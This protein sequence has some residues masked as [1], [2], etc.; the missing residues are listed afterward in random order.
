M[1][2]R[3]VAGVKQSPVLSIWSLEH[4]PLPTK[5]LDSFVGIQL[6]GTPLE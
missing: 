2:I 6:S 5:S 3:S 4:D 1:K